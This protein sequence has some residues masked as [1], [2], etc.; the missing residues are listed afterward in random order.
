MSARACGSERA[1]FGPATS[2]TTLTCSRRNRPGLLQ[3]G[4]PPQA[5]SPRP[6]A[7]ESGC[8]SLR[9]CARQPGRRLLAWLPM[10]LVIERAMHIH[11][12]IEVG[13]YLVVTHQAPK[14][15]APLLLHALAASVREP[16][17]LRSAA[18]AILRCPVGIDFDRTGALR[19]GFLAGMLID[20][21]A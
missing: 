12:R 8:A 11:A 14:Q 9:R 1:P 2:R 10:P 6:L 3:R 17:A 16:L 4:V 5:S 19:E 15:L 13:L 20:F 18:R 7:G 21:A